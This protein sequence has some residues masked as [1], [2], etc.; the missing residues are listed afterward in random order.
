MD[1]CW[2]VWSILLF[3]TIFHKIFCSE[4]EFRLLRDLRQN[5]DPVE[6]PVKNHSEP[7]VVK[8][9]ILLQQIVDVDEKNQVLTVV[10]W[11]QTNFDARFPVNF[12]VSYTGEVLHAPPAI[13]MCS[14]EIDITWF[15][16]DEQLCVLKYGVWTYSKPY[17]DIVLDEEGLQTNQ[18]MNTEYYIKNGE[19][20][21]LGTDYL[22]NNT[23]YA[24]DNYP[25]HLI[26]LLIRRRTIYYGMNWIVPSILFYT[27]NVLGFTLP[28]ECGE[29][30]TL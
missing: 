14:C 18:S 19:W 27:S 30:I 9:K 28:P 7:V 11:F 25:V 2:R 16:F 17:V 8:L 10:L 1:G 24:N 22:K 21:L 15:P 12:V 3:S 26:Y 13:V 4:D 6:R 23:G 29:K 5:Y 20:D